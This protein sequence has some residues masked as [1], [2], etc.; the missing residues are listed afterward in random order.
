LAGPIDLRAI[1]HTASPGFFGDCL[2]WYHRPHDER[3]TKWP[4]ID[5]V[6]VGAESG[7]HA[8]PLHVEWVRGIVRQC[9]DAGTPVLVKQMGRDVL[10]DGISSPGGHWPRGIVREPLPRFV[11]DDPPFVVRLRAR[12][13]E[14]MNEWPEDLRVRG[15]PQ[16]T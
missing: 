2:E 15:F 10:D 5:W 13:G 4:G 7:P 8:R 1:K 14:D 16:G 9:R 6:I 11:C 12:K 3:F